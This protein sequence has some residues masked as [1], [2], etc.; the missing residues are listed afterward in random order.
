MWNRK[1]F[2]RTAKAQVS[3]V[4]LIFL[5]F[6]GIVFAIGLIYTL[7]SGFSMYSSL[8]GRT[9]RYYSNS[10][11]QILKLILSLFTAS[12]V[13]SL[14]LLAV[15]IARGYYELKS[16]MMSAHDG[17]KVEIGRMFKTGSW[18]EFFSYFVKTLIAALIIG[19]VS[20]VGTLIIGIIFGIGAATT[21]GSSIGSQSYQPLQG[22]GIVGI[23]ALVLSVALSIYLIILKYQLMLVKYIALDQPDLGIWATIKLSAAAMKGN[24]WHMFVMQLSFIGW[25]LLVFITFGILSIYVNPYYALAETHA[26]RGVIGTN[27]GAYTSES[28]PLPAAPVMPVIPPA[29]PAAPEM[30][31]RYAAPAAPEQPAQALPVV[32]PAVPQAQDTAAP[33]ETS[34][35]T[36]EDSFETFEG[37]K[38]CPN[39][40]AELT[41]H[42]N[43]FCTHCGARLR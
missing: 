41:A 38:F 32:P 21:V 22:L 16:C 24:K 11:E 26:F 20:F 7:G 29:A 36:A 9:S 18:K 8:I 39:C 19:G 23:I 43:K 35:D 27:Q 14:L 34:N 10:P 12:I 3:N 30:Q 37:M 6:I 40:G 15:R 1:L 17:Q 5:M 28:A 4:F 2:K 13:W 33:V 42:D 25:Y 31:N